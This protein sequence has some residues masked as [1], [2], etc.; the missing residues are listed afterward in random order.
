MFHSKTNQVQKDPK[1]YRIIEVLG[2]G[3]FGKVVKI[4]NINDPTETLAAKV[5]LFGDYH[6]VENETKGTGF[7]S[8]IIDKI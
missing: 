8:S 5:V 7:F 3:N 6:L 1:N 4:E 2:S